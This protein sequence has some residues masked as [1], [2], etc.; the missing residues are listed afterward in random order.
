MNLAIAAGSALLVALLCYLAG[1]S[2]GVDSVSRDWLKI[3]ADHAEVVRK[4]THQH[5]ERERHWQQQTQEVS[6]ALSARISATASARDAV[7]A[8]LR[9]DSLRLRERFQGCSD[10]VPSA[11]EPA[12]IDDGAAE[13]GLSRADQEFLVRIAAEADELAAKLLACQSYVRSIQ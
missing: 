1:Y 2:A 7:L 8:D 9:D 6:D 5:R 3:E 13:A 11:A 4:L 10:R 12:R